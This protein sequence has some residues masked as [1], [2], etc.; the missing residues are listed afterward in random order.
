MSIS[1]IILPTHLGPVKILHN[2]DVAHLAVLC[3]GQSQK[4]E[5][6][7]VPQH[8]TS[9]EGKKDNNNKKTKTGG[10]QRDGRVRHSKEKQTNLSAT[11]P[12]HF[13]KSNKVKCTTIPPNIILCYKLFVKKINK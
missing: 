8:S 5:G 6:Y 11:L 2:L 1:L 3:P 9:E 12:V 4:A 7:N 13:H 10:K